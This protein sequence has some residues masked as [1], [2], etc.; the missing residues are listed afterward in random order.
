LEVGVEAVRDVVDMVMR[1][2]RVVVRRLKEKK[3]D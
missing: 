1:P 2:G 3:D